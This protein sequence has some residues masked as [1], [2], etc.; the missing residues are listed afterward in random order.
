MLAVTAANASCN[1]AIQ[2]PT[3]APAGQT[4]VSTFPGY[5][6]DVGVGK[7]NTERLKPKDPKVPRS[8]ASTA[9]VT[10]SEGDNDGA[11]GSYVR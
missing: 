2:H 10:S 4:T 9:S 1:A 6:P 3:T 11:A 5:L 7:D 8:N